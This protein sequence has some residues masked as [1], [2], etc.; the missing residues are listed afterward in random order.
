M[1]HNFSHFVS[2]L[3]P[4]YTLSEQ[5]TT[6]KTEYLDSLQL[7][8]AELLFPRIHDQTY[9]YRTPGPMG[10]VQFVLS[11]SMDGGRTNITQKH[12]PETYFW[13]DDKNIEKWKK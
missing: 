9:I 8:K 10:K 5:S 3:L 6:E 4:F 12:P 11:Y 1:S 13:L 2:P 7:E